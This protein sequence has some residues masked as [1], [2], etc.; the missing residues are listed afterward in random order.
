MGAT[1][2]QGAYQMGTGSA[3]SAWQREGEKIISRICEQAKGRSKSKPVGSMDRGRGRGTGEVPTGW[4]DQEPSICDQQ[5]Q[6]DSD[7][8]FDSE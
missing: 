6:T 1:T 4:Q 2:R 7:F 8:H 3:S 5:H